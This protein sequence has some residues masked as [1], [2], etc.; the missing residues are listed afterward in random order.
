M[1]GVQISINRRHMLTGLAAAPAIALPSNADAANT[2]AELFRLEAEFN[3][4]DEQW[5]AASTGLTK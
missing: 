2:D 3:A 1:G 4:A 5:Q